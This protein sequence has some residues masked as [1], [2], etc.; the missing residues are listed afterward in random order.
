MLTEIVPQRTGLVH[1]T[2]Q[3]LIAFLLHIEHGVL[4]FDLRVFVQ[5][6]SR[7]PIQVIQQI[8]RD[9]IQRQRDQAEGTDSAYADHLKVF[10]VD[11]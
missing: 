3:F 5:A 9:R 2:A 6:H 8:D 11:V 1:V 4:L 10:G 7:P